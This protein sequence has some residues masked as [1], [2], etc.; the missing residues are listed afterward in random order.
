MRVVKLGDAPESEVSSVP[1]RAIQKRLTELKSEAEGYR[2]RLKDAEARIEELEAIAN[3]RPR[4]RGSTGKKAEALSQRREALEAILRESGPQ[5][6]KKLH[7]AAKRRLGD[8]FTLGMFYRTLKAFGDTFDQPT[9][10]QWG[11]KEAEG[12]SKKRAN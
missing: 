2:E 12:G 10:G 8:T 4:R 1:L 7:E 9:H 5:S 11:L 6:S 3:T